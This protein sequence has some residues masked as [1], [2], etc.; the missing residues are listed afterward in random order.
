V[1]EFYHLVV[2]LAFKSGRVVSPLYG[3]VFYLAANR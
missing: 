2:Y 1:A 3:P